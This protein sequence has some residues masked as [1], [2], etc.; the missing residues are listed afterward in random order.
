MEK[1][2][3]Q[4]HIIDAAGRVLGRIAQEAALYL[5]GKNR[6]NYQHY[7]DQGDFV[8]VVNT[9]QVKL[10]GRKMKQ[11]KYYKHTGYLGHLK[12]KSVENVFKRSSGEVVRRA[13][14]GM[15]PT[16]K[17]RDKMITRLKCYGKEK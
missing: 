3:R 1:I 2:E 4:Q 14:Y 17:L 6:P 8:T 10:T 15:L 16:N 12:I 13:V 9:D 7:L 5:R 11:K